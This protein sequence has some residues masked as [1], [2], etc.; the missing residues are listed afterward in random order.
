M[1]VAM[2]ASAWG[3]YLKDVDLKRYPIVVAS[4]DEKKNISLL[5]E[6]TSKPDFVFIH[7]ND[8]WL[9]GTMSGWKEAG[10][11]YHGIL[12]AADTFAYLNGTPRPELKCDVAF[13]GGYWGYKARNLDRYILPL[14]HP[15]TGLGVKI[16]GN[17]PWPVHQ[18]LGL[19]EDETVKD[20]FASAVVCPN[21]SEPHSTDD[22]LGWDVIERPFKVLSSGG[23]CVSDYCPEA[24][25][26]LFTG[27]ELVFAKTP[28][29]FAEAIRHF[30]AHPED[31]Q[32]Y[33]LRGRRKVLGQHTYFHRVAQMFDALG[34][35]AESARTLDLHEKLVGETL[36]S[37]ND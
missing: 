24:A 26:S 6:M 20:L 18:Y 12:N 36:R 32:P 15:S 19:V 29:D 5:K 33:I 13:V 9:E 11:P 10:V 34:L 27:G 37:L 21:V 31:R 28:D 23:F 8:R 16:F 7:A 4:E 14:C 35:P 3:P 22:G 17:Q 1:K 25:E 30:V 2:Y